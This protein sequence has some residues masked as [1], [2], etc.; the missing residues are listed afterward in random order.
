MRMK[1]KILLSFLSVISVLTVSISLLA[2]YTTKPHITGTIQAQ[3]RNH[4]PTTMRLVYPKQ[5]K[6]N[7]VWFYTDGKTIRQEQ[8][9]ELCN[10][11]SCFSCSQKIKGTGFGLF[12]VKTIIE[13]HGG[14][15][16]A[17]QGPVGNSF[18]FHLPY[19]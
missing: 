16:G 18:V 11:S 15:G 8:T 14:R 13:G 7:D 12:I 5:L 2:V 3:V 1:T 10:R 19:V 9:K 17:S 6:K 4:L